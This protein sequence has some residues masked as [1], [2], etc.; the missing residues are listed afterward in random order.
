V[1]G[2]TQPPSSAVNQRSAASI[3]YT[4][5]G[6]VTPTTPTAPA[7]PTRTLSPEHLAYQAAHKAQIRAENQYSSWSKSAFSQ[8]EA[9]Q[10]QMQASIDSLTRGQG[11]ESMSGQHGLQYST[12]TK[13]Y[14]GSDVS[15]TYLSG[16][17]YWNVSRCVELA[18]PAPT[19]STWLAAHAAQ[20]SAVENRLIANYTA[21]GINTPWIPEVYEAYA[22]DGKFAVY[23]K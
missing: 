7:Q 20:R 19:F 4:W 9:I 18:N 13:S 3:Q 11:W 8:Y 14:H 2:A 15:F 10:N 22:I 16:Y 5:H 17:W 21:N 23:G 1:A 6:K 12:A